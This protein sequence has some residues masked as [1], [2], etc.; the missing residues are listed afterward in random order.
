MERGKVGYL[1]IFRNWTSSS[2]GNVVLRYF[3]F[4]LWWPF[5][6]AEQNSLCNFGRWHYEEHSCQI[7]YNLDQRSGG[8]FV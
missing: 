4:W 3:Y 6:S 8:D 5:C 1:T 2:G 7:I